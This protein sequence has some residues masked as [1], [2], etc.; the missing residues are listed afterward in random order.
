MHDRHFLVLIYKL[1]FQKKYPLDEYDIQL[2][3][4]TPP[5]K[6]LK[7]LPDIIITKDGNVVLWVEVGKLEH[8]KAVAVLDLIGTEKFHHIPYE[9]ALFRLPTDKQNQPSLDYAKT[10]NQN[11]VTQL[12]DLEKKQVQ[13]ALQDSN[14]SQPLA[15]HQLGITVRQIRYRIQKYNLTQF[16]KTFGASL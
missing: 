12:S 10:K 5:I 6:N 11:I 3:P 14:F 13:Q 1:L 7:Y 15:A 2:D 8:A 4:R 9:H 16:I